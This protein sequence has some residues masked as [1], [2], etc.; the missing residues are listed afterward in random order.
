MA[1]VLGAVIFSF[2]LG[3]LCTSVFYRL[4]STKKVLTPP[5]RRARPLLDQAPIG[6]IQVDEENRLIY[7]N[8]C[9]VKL[10][11]VKV[12][13][14]VGKKKE[15]LLKWVRSYELDQLIT[16]VRAGSEQGV[17]DWVW[18]AVVPDPENP[19]PQPSRALRGYGLSL[20]HGQ[21][22]IFLVDRQEV[23]ELTQQCDRWTADIAHELKTPLTAIRLVAETLQNQVN[24]QAR[25]WLDRLLKE[26]LRLSDLVQDLLELSQT[27]H[28]Q[29]PSLRLQTLNLVEIVE[30]AWQTLE[31]LAQKCQVR[32]ECDI[33]PALEI[34]GDQE[35]LGRLF[36]NLLDN[37]IRHSPAL[38]Q[39][40]VTASAETG[41]VV[42]DVI[43]CGSGFS[44][45]I[46][47][48]VF[49]RFYRGDPSRCRYTQGGSG[50]GLSIAQQI[51]HLH[52]GQIQ[53]MNHPDT[54]GAQVRVCLPLKH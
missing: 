48:H 10:L 46:L 54:G 53:A 23:V 11:G 42:I 12:P 8:P 16:Q 51:V 9:S 25:P 18:Q 33:A 26:V 5:S 15:P 43:D 36:L 49:E 35:R 41:E 3:V 30:S 19:L 7:C 39:I 40:L 14:F 44:P 29:K 50:L 4:R 45:E 38:Q 21:V 20:S 37:S 17:K 2:G 1:Q 28:G 34:N 27:Y 24:D 6:Y 52:G 47:G 32:L 22:G 13:D 31:P